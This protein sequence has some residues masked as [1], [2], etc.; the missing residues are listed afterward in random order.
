MSLCTA[1]SAKSR[2]TL[3]P[4]TGRTGGMGSGSTKSSATPAEA[5]AER[6]SGLM[7]RAADL[8][9]V[10][11]HADSIVKVRRH[12]FTLCEALVDR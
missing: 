8:L 12:C 7:A 4:P 2:S 1:G 3:G 11:S 5:A 9:L 6:L 10:L